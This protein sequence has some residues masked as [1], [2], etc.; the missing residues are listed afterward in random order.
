MQDIFKNYI[1]FVSSK[2]S[3]EETTEMGYRT[4]FEILLKEIFKSINV[5]RFDHDARAKE[6]N[7]PDFVVVKHGVP[8]LYIET[9]NIGTSLDRIEKSEQMRRYYGYTNLVLTDYLEFRFYRNG[10]YYVEPIK[11]AEY[12][13]KTRKITPIPDSYE[14][15]ARTLIDF[16]ESQKEPIK[17]GEHLAKIMGGNKELGII[18]NNSLLQ[19]RKKMKSY[20]RY[21]K[22]LKNY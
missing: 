14:Y 10:I 8:I 3:H 20:S 17:K 15:L 18:L 16:T 4:D 5:T 1:Q 21:M 6:G 7:K 13:L 19:N 22:L 9:K 12:D 2:F 11:I